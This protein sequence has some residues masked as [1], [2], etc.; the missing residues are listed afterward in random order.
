MTI[1]NHFKSLQC[2]NAK[3]SWCGTTWESPMKL[4]TFSLTWMMSMFWP[5]TILNPSRHRRNSVSEILN[6]SLRNG[7]SRPAMQCQCMCL[8]YIS[9]LGSPLLMTSLSLRLATLILITIHYQHHHHHHHQHQHHHHYLITEVL[10]RED[11]WL[12]GGGVETDS[13]SANSW[14]S[15]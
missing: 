6:P 15:N 11:C 2:I 10:R 1:Y 4:V 13:I 3:P 5:K 8:G 12:D 14:Y 9:C 7:L